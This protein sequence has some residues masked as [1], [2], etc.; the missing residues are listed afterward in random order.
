MRFVTTACGQSSTIS[1]A[2][3]RIVGVGIFL[4]SVIFEVIMN[5]KET[6][7]G[8]NIPKQP[9]DAPRGD[10]GGDAKTWE[11]PRGEQG[12]SNRQGDEDSGAK[13]REPRTA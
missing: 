7:P 2:A 10:G 11:P 12:V 4:A 13:T 8:A 6:N 5:S 1:P 9:P 3:P